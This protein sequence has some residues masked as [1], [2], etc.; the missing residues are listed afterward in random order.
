MPVFLHV[1]CG[2]L[3]KNQTTR[4]FDTP[5]W[6]ELRLDID[7]AVQP[8]LIG[9]MTDMAAVPDGAVDAVYSS[10]NIEHLHAH[11]VPVA[12]AEFLRVLRAD[13][14]AVIAC[15][16][17]RSVAALVVEDKLTEPAYASTLGPISPLDM[18]YGQQ[19]AVAQGNLHMAH[20]TG[21]TSRSLEAALRKAGFASVVLLQRPW[22]FELWALG[23][24]RR[25]PP[26][27]LRALMQ[28]HF[29]LR[30]APAAPT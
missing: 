4:G 22:A 23:T 20:R 17:L 3:R 24:K 5:D 12:L 11:E 19:S 6:Q 16:D 10:H 15:P 28:A 7:P 1:G 25:L 14:F 27:A 30:S 8:D 9:T 13:G 21:F 26:D 2:R 18:I 29:P